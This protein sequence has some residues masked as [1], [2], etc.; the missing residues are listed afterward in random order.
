MG[1]YIFICLLFLISCGNAQDLPDEDESLLQSIDNC[2]EKYPDLKWGYQPPPTSCWGQYC[3]S[4]EVEEEK[5]QDEI[6]CEN[7]LEEYKK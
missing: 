1:K 2:I 5:T 4:V 3:P 7:L 6:D